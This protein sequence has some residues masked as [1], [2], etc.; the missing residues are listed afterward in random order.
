MK[1][2]VIFADSFGYGTQ[3]NP[4]YSNIIYYRWKLDSFKASPNKLNMVISAYLK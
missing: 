3:T 1:T 4:S 2:I